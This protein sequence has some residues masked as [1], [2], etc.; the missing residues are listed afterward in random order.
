MGGKEL[1]SQREKM[2]EEMNAQMQE[3]SNDSQAKTAKTKMS[4]SAKAKA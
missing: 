3:K 4:K 2:C 1:M